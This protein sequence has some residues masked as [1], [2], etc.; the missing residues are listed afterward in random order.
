MKDVHKNSEK[1]LVKS[2]Q[3]QI[4]QSQWH[5]CSNTKQSWILCSSRHQSR[6]TMKKVHK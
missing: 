6:G 5:K 3:V 2:L 4:Q 1:I